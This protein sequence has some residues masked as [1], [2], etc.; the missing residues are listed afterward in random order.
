[1]LSHRGLG[2][3]CLPVPASRDSA[4]GEIRTRIRK[5]LSFPCLPVAS[6]EQRCLYRESNP[7]YWFRG[8]V[9]CSL[10]YRGIGGN[11]WIRTSTALR[12]DGV[13]DRWTTVIPHFQVGE[14]VYYRAML[15]LLQ[16]PMA[17]IEPAIFP[18]RAGCSTTELHRLVRSTRVRPPYSWELLVL[19][20]QAWIMTQQQGYA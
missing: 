9:L 4:P 14:A 13:L 16:E 1:M 11:G 15:S 7:D 10:S 12:L 17:G 8:P 3:V 18:I 20:G 5:G 19:A 2:P 6:P